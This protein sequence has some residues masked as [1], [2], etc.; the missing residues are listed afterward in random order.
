[1]K[2]NQHIALR[3]LLWIICTYH[4]VC[5]LIPNLFPNHA[6]ALAERLSGMNIQAAPQFIAL[7][8]PFGIYAITFGIMMGLAAWNP[9]KNR[10]LITVGVILFAL[11]IFQRLTGLQEAEQVFGVTPDRSMITIA[12]VSCFAIALTWLRIMLYREM[13][14]DDTNCAK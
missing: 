11:R 14:R 3:G 2:T 8:K 9:V 12:I 1:M 10:A 4:I 5:G 13:K 6:L 7:T